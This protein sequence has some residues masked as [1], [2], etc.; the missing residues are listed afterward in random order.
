MSA[1]YASIDAL[2]GASPTAAE[3]VELPD[4]RVVRVR[5]LTR[6]ELLLNGRGAEGNAQLIEARHLA[7]CMVAPPVTIDQAEQLQR[8]TGP[9]YLLP[10]MT[11]I[12]RLSG[13]DEGAAKSGLPADG[14]RQRD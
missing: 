11:T 2:F 8:E 7:T 6:Y 5:G 9:M 4:G 12:R 3:D 1:D 13:L 10:I 14:E